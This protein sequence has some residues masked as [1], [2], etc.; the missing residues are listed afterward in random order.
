MITK[1][2]ELDLNKQPDDE[3]ENILMQWI[4]EMESEWEDGPGPYDI[5]GATDEILKT[6]TPYFPDRNKEEWR[7]SI[8]AGLREDIK[9]DQLLR[10]SKKTIEIGVSRKRKQRAT[11]EKRKT[12]GGLTQEQ[13][14]ARD[15]KIVEH[16]KT[17]RL[18][19]A[20]FAKKHAA[21]HKLSPRTV[22]LILSKAVGS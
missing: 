21:E 12:W 15:Q 6:L 9:E 17:T 4:D 5:Q 8:E 3:L 13:L 16:F 20:S 18:T 1:K 19:A 10:Y 22:R 7:K 11:R 2:K 14:S